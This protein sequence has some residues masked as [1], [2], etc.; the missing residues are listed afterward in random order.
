M[1]DEL[2]PVFEQCGQ[3]YEFRLM[4]D[5][6]GTNRGFG[7]VTYTSKLAAHRACNELNNYE[8]RQGRHLG[9]VQSVD[10]CRLFMGGIPRNKT[11]EDV[12]EEISRLTDGVVDV[13]LYPS[14][15][16]KTKN[17]GFAFIEYESHKAATIAR[18]K[19][20]PGRITLW[21][22]TIAVDWAEPEQEPDEEV[23]SQV[24][25]LTSSKFATS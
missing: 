18:R 10:N 19:L 6:S 9:V 1:E 22:S 7:F 23:M 11:R 21:G 16:D 8:I 20:I 24:R 17:R 25:N 4:M 3:I 13:I 14:A 15:N 5:F 2:I 12:K